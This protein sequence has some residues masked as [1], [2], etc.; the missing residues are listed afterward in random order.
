MAGP[1]VRYTMDE[2][3]ALIGLAVP[4]AELIQSVTDNSGVTTVPDGVKG[5]AAAFSGTGAERIADFYPELPE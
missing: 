4:R 3:G 2:S 1:S 5:R